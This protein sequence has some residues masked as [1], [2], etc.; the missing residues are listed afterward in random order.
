[1]QFLLRSEM[2]A[3]SLQ[4]ISFLMQWNGCKNRGTLLWGRFQQFVGI[5]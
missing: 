4:E 2:D 1:M 3:A 5:N